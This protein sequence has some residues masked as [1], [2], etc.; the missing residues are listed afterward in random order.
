MIELIL[1][2]IIG[3]ALG[4]IAMSFVVEGK[5]P[6]LDWDVNELEDL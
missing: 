3:S 1:G 4:I 2:I 6:A 5:T